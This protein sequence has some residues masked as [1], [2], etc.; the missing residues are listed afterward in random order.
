[1]TLAHR[2]M[3]NILK[4]SKG[5]KICIMAHNANSSSCHLIKGVRIWHSNFQWC[6]DDRYGFKYT[7]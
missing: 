6:T 7:I 2:S 3:S 4:V 1:M 5:A